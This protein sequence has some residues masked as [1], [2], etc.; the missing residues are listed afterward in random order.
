MLIII[1]DANLDRYDITVEDL[2]PLQ[3]SDVHAHLIFIGSLGDEAFELADRIPNDRA[4]VC[5][6]S[7]QL[8]LIIKKIVT[9]ALR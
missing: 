9:T 6:T 8:P 2:A 1:S 4:Q 3:A 7:S 5:E